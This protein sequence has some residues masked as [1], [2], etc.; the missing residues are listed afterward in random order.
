MGPATLTQSS[1]SSSGPP[2]TPKIHHQGGRAEEEKCARREDEERGSRRRGRSRWEDVERGEGGEGERHAFHQR[3]SPYYEVFVCG[4]SL[5][6][7]RI[8]L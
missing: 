8:G 2:K 5:G 6:D 4:A 3:A 7:L 1:L